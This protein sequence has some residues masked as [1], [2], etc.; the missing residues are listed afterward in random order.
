MTD[1]EAT[2]ESQLGDGA[3][4]AAVADGPEPETSSPA[5]Q[6]LEIALRE[7]HERGEAIVERGEHVVEDVEEVAQLVPK[8]VTLATIAGAGAFLIG[9]AL[10]ARAAFK[11]RGRRPRR[12]RNHPSFA[13]TLL[14]GVLVSIANAAASRLASNVLLP[15]FEEQLARRASSHV[16]LGT[17][18]AVPH[19]T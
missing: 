14:R 11:R 7:L 2:S 12:A 6:N 15:A 4:P 13:T 1:Q 5:E 19:R 8:G 18:A 16:A 9:T 10:L 3:E 17:I